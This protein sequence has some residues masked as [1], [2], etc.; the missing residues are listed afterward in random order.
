MHAI[1]SIEFLKV[2]QVSPAGVFSVASR[3]KLHLLAVVRGNACTIIVNDA[4]HAF[5]ALVLCW[6]HAGD[7]SLWGW[8]LLQLGRTELLQIVRRMHVMPRLPGAASDIA[9]VLE[10]LA[11]RR[12]CRHVQHL[13]AMCGHHCRGLLRQP[14]A[15]AAA[16]R[17]HSRLYARSDVVPVPALPAGAGLP[18][19]DDEHEPDA[20]P[21]KDERAGDARVGRRGRRLSRRHRHGHQLVLAS[22]RRLAPRRMPRL[23]D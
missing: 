22:R 14:N 1:M 11:V 6:R 3:E 8:P 20:N 7:G 23:V 21:L 12:L 2:A 5:E 19:L 10:M 17:P 16:C 4:L 13:S 9:L 18:R 15:H